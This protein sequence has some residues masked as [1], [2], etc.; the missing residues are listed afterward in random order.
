M[1]DNFLRKRCFFRRIEIEPALLIGD[2]ALKPIADHKVNVSD[3]RSYISDEN[4]DLKYTSGRKQKSV[5]KEIIMAFTIENGVLIKYTEENGTT[6]ITIPDGVTEIGEEAFWGCE[7]VKI[8]RLPNNHVKIGYE[9]FYGISIDELFVPERL[10]DGRS[11][12][13][14]L[15]G[16]DVNK[17]VISPENEALIMRDDILYSKDMTILFRAP[18]NIEKIVI[19]DTASEIAEYAFFECEQLREAVISNSVKVIGRNAFQGCASLEK[20]VIPDSVSEISICTFYNCTSLKDVTL[21]E[22]LTSICAYAFAFTA[23]ENIVIPKQVSLLGEG[24]F[25]DCKDLTEV[26]M[27]DNI[28]QMQAFE[29]LE[30]VMYIGKNAFQRCTPLGICSFN[31]CINT[32]ENY[33]YWLYDAE[34]EEQLLKAVFI[35]TPWLRSQGYADDE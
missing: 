9:A 15:L 17:I 21:P 23:I 29:Y 24:A 32:C 18:K 16:S 19:P 28:K 26:E 13:I 31:D 33:F 10:K 22:N 1:T 3:I 27:P 20:I 4:I 11:L 2:V 14:G 8:I 7:G 34:S 6:E 25:E 12:T 30:S 5:F 35:G